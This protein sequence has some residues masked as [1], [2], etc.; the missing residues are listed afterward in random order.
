MA[1]SQI[2][3]KASQ[4]ERLSQQLWIIHPD[5]Q[6]GVSAKI[7]RQKK[8]ERTAERV[9]PSN[10]HTITL[11]EAQQTINETSDTQRAVNRYS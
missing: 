7:P 10:C 1:I 11:L 9:D 2:H 4:E 3:G 5:V 8:E 6:I